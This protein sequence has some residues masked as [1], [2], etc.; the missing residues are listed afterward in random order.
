MQ[1]CG[2]SLDMVF[3][4]EHLETRQ[5]TNERFSRAGLTAMRESVFELIK[6]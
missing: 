3:L 1:L 4:A 2:K 5:V 6:L